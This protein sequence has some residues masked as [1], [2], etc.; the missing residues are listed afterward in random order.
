MKK[1]ILDT[2]FLL[3]PAQFNIDVFSEIDK[4]ADFNYEL[5]VL[6]KTLDELKKIIEQQ[7]GKHKAAAKLALDIVKAKK[8]MILKTGPGNVDGLLLEQ[9]DAII[10]TSDK[11][12]IKR[13]KNRGIKTIRLRQKQYLKLE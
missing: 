6:D 2:N 9:N 5:C 12:L 11:E 10:A 13:L 8:L 4:I 7:K 3:I 1:I